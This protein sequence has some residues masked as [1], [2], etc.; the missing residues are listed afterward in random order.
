MPDPDAEVGSFADPQAGKWHLIDLDQYIVLRIILIYITM[1][2]IF[3]QRIK[4]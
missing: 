2:F 4:D 3:R 1:Q